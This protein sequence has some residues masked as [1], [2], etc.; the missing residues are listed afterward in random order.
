MRPRLHGFPGGTCPHSTLTEGDDVCE[1]RWNTSE[2]G[3][4]SAEVGLSSGCMLVSSS[5]EAGEGFVKD[6]PRDSSLALHSQCFE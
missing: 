5:V 6:L 3:S 4:S 1:F 2:S